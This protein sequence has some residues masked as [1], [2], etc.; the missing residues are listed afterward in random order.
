MFLCLD[1]DGRRGI[2]RQVPQ[3]SAILLEL[4]HGVRAA[5]LVF[6]E[7]EARGGEFEA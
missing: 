1:V 5:F 2:I 3:H 6:L 7:D 4:L